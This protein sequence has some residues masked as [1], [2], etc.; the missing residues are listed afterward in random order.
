MNDEDMSKKLWGELKPKLD[1]QWSEH[2][3][4]L[5]L[6]AASAKTPEQKKTFEA[7]LRKRAGYPKRTYVLVAKVVLAGIVVFAFTTWFLMRH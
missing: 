4:F 2:Q 3:R 7:Y 1:E 6:V 5:G